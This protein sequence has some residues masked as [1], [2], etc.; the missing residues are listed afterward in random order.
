MF[1]DGGSLEK[2]NVS[3]YSDA[4]LM[5][6]RGG[7]FGAPCLARAPSLAGAPER[8]F[9]QASVLTSLPGRAPRNEPVSHPVLLCCLKFP[10]HG[11]SRSKIL[12]SFCEFRR[13]FSSCGFGE[14]V[15]LM[16]CCWCG[17]RR[18]TF[19]VRRQAAP[20]PCV[21]LGLGSTPTGS[22]H[23]CVHVNPGGPQDLVP[24]ASPFTWL[25]SPPPSQCFL[26]A[27]RAGGSGTGP[28]KPGRQMSA[29]ADLY[30]SSCPCTEV[31][32]E[33]TEGASVWGNGRPLVFMPGPSGLMPVPTLVTFLTVLL[34]FWP[35]CLSEMALLSHW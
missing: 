16:F 18:D 29:R 34:G 13:M 30:V 11:K 4:S 22:L 17:F 27:P 20:R 23:P 33:Q 14:S 3:N 12:E 1:A 15:F 32:R 26:G 8:S 24:V 7:G 28:S 35:L 2:Q 10:L 6:P 5:A 31:I 21:R 9:R 19:S 25:F